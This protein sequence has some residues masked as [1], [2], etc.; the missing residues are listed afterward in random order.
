MGTAGHQPRLELAQDLVYPADIGL[1]EGKDGGRGRGRFAGLEFDDVEGQFIGPGN[2]R[3]FVIGQEIAGYRPQHL[4]AQGPNVQ[5]GPI[6]DHV[7]QLKPHHLKEMKRRVFPKRLA[8]G[9]SQTG[10]L[11]CSIRRRKEAMIRR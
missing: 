10:F 4:I 2:S 8:H 5:V 1:E 7:F 3:L 11:R 6:H 9:L